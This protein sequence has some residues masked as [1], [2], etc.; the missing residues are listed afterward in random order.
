MGDRANEDQAS[1]KRQTKPTDG[2]QEDQSQDDVGNV[3]PST[4]NLVPQSTF[5]H[6]LWMS[7]GRHP[8]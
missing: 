6:R 5:L 2:S 3:E 8:A 7:Q 4:V 1:A